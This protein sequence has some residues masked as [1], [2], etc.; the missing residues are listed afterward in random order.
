[1]QDR[2]GPVLLDVKS[3]IW[4]K[5]LP[6]TKIEKINFQ[7]NNQYDEISKS[8]NCLKEEISSSQRPLLLLGDGFRGK[9]NAIK[10]ILIFSKN[11][12][13]PILSGRFSQDLFSQSETYFGYIGS[14]G[15]R[16][17]NFILSKSDLVIAIGNR[18][19]YP[20]K[21]KSWGK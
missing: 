15:L 19:H 4:N 11:N 13:I 8:L 18:M 14:H 10:E 16:S 3:N 7:L 21:S 12:N 17:G 20:T 2:Q 5:E 6:K 9:K 1:M